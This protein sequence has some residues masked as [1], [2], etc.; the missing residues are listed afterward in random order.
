MR[1]VV[2]APLPRADMFWLVS[3]ICRMVAVSG[4]DVI[5]AVCPN[6]VAVV[7]GATSVKDGLEK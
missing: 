6:G 1:K 3:V 7:D 5:V 4:F 2:A